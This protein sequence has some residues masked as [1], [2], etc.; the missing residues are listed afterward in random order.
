MITA[1]KNQGWS[2]AEA[3]GPARP[4]NF[5][6]DGPRFGPARHILI[7]WA[8]AR[9]GPSNFQRMGRGP[10]WL[11]KFSEDGPRPGP[12]HH[13]F[14]NSRPGPAHH[15]FK[16]LGRPDP[17]HHMATRPMKHGLYIG[18]PDNYVGR[19]VD[20]KGRPMTRP[21]CCPVLTGAGAYA[22][23]ILER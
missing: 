3:G 12:A 6:Y 20:L 7:W 11:F 16:S 9:P 17:A 14:K 19:P 1:G 10:A 2:W 8:A 22:D 13:I 18:R 23:M 5:L 4:I 15:F 21:M